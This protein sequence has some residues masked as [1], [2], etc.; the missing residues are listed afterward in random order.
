LLH[1]LWRRQEFSLLIFQLRLRLLRL[2]WCQRLPLLLL[3][4]KLI[5]I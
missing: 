4:L 1:H 3:L 2:L 5:I